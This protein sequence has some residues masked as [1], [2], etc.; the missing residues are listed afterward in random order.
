WIPPFLVEGKELSREAM[1]WF[2]PLPLL[3]GA[4]GGV[5]GGMLNDLFLRRYRRPRWTRSLIAFVG[6]FLAALLILA[7]LPIHD[8]RLVVAV[9]VASRFFNDWSL[10]TQWGAIT[11]MGGKGAATLFGVVNMIGA[12]GG[13]AAGPLLGYL[14]QYHGW[15]GLFLGVAAAYLAAALTWLFIDCTKRVVVE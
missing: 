1:G 13:F 5:V 12:L 15:E 6:K 9:L 11:D 14:K 10:P 8:G 4:L 2:A 7:T 3:G